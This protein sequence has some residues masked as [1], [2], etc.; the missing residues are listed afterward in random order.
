MKPSLIFKRL[1]FI[2]VSIIIPFFSTTFAREKTIRVMADR[3]VSSLPHFWNSFGIGHASLLFDP[4]LR[5]HVE[6]GVRNLGMKYIRFHGIL[7]DD[8]MIYREPSGKPKYSFKRS[9]EIFDFL[10]SLGIIPIVE[11]GSMPEDLAKDKSK[12]VFKWKQHISP[13]KNF[14]IWEDLI[15]R[16][17]SHYKSRYGEGEIEKWYFEVWNEPELESFWSGTQE[18]YHKLYEHTLKGAKRAWPGIRIGGPTPSGP[19]K[20]SKIDD[21]LKFVRTVETAPSENYS[22]IDF[23]SFHSWNWI[24]DNVESPDLIFQILGRFKEYPDLEI[25]NT[26]WG[27]TWQFNLDPQPQETLRGASFVVNVISDIAR[28][29]YEKG[30]PFPKTYTYW[31]LSDIFEEG[32]YREEY[33]FIGCM[34]LISREGIYKPPYN[35]FRMLDMLGSTILKTEI[36]SDDIPVGAIATKGEWEDDVSLLIYNG[37]YD[38]T[39]S[40]QVHLK[41]EGMPFERGRY[42]IY[43]LD[44]DH[45]NSYA[46]WKSMGSP[47]KRDM[48]ESDWKTLR[49][50]MTISPSPDKEEISLKG[51]FFEEKYN[52]VKEGVVLIRISP[53]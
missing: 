35:A 30:I 39:G 11:F 37:G 22:K 17:V 31:V 47:K 7:H 40:D 29:S 16:M 53:L 8:M 20:F 36:S 4:A 49:D 42:S 50:S 24:K 18:E 34:G 1:L 41:I 27:P 46:R 28:I 52:I 45:G 21:L 3:P 15:Y 38:K 44:Q 5:K 23:I 33:P 25:L 13:P 43:R 48:S 32:T 51:G 2:Y 9:D 14:Q 19:W 6:D 10:I 12:T 26:E